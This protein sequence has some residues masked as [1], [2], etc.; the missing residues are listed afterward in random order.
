MLFNQLR[1]TKYVE[2]ILLL[3]NIKT[4]SMILANDNSSGT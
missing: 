3:Y 1:N 2:H 4:R